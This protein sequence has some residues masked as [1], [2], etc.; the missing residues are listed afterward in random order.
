MDEAKETPPPPPEDLK[1][2]P[3]DSWELLDTPKDESVD[4][5]WDVSDSG[6]LYKW[7]LYHAYTCYI[8]V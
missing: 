5:A 1:I 4:E 7:V 3:T 6:Q 2:A 8:Y